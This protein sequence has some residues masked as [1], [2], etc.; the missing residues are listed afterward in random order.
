[1]I[2]YQLVR[3]RGNFC[4]PGN[5]FLSREIRQANCLHIK[6]RV[7]GASRLIPRVKS[8]TGDITTDPAEIS[9]I[10]SDYYSE[11][12]T[13]ESS[14]QD[15]DS[16]NPLETLAYPQVDGRC[17]GDLGAPLASVTSEMVIKSLQ[18]G[19]SPGPDGYSTEF[20]KTFCSVLAPILLSIQ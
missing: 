7:A 18:S 12:Y 14:P 1:M 16:P 2:C 5:D 19:K 13:S 6:S 11:L 17:S 9:N 15:W 8:P 3:S 20:F 10:F 4:K